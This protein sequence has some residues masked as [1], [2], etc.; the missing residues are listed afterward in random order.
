MGWPGESPV[1][2]QRAASEGW[3]GGSG[4]VPFQERKNKRAWKDYPTNRT[5]LAWERARPGL[6]G[7]AGENEARS[8]GLPEAVAVGEGY[9]QVWEDHR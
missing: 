6:P 1:L 4:Q 7:W 3:G 9:E 5:V 8:C 2:A